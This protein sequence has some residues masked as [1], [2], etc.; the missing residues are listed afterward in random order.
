MHET[1]WGQVTKEIHCKMG[2]VRAKKKQRKN[3]PSRENRSQVKCENIH[4]SLVTV[5]A[6]EISVF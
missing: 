4:I 1:H 3:K 2:H 5:W 6:L